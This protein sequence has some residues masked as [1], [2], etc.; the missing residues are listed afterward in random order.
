VDVDGNRGKTVM[1]FPFD[2]HWNKDI[3]KFANM[4]VADRIGQIRHQLS[5]DE[6]HVIEAVAMVCSGGTRDNSAFLDFLRWWAVSNHDYETFMESVMGFKLKCGQSS[7][8]LKFLH[9]SLQTGNLSYS[10]NTAVSHIDSSGDTVEVRVKDGRRFL[11]RR[12]V[13]TIPLNVLAKVTFNP[14]LD[15]AKVEA[16]ALKHVNQCAKVHAEVKDPEMRSW[17]GVTYPNNKL[18]LGAGD[19]TTPSGNTH[20]VFFGCEENHLQAD[21]NIEETLQAV[22]EFAPMDVERLVRLCFNSLTDTAVNAWNCR[23]FITG[24]RTNSPKGHGK[25]TLG[26]SCRVNLADN[27]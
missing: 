10:F 23:F 19:G 16:S 7:F 24:P 14:P 22:K 4:S 20:I 18:V 3:L 5:E 17:S 1:P 26:R 15:P 9:E 11:A 25:F 12:V 2:S 13:S 6:R 27:I 21:E 8:A